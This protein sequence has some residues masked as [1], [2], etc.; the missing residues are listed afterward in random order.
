V[1][2][3]SVQPLSRWRR[4]RLAAILP[5]SELSATAYPS[6]PRK[7]PPRP[8]RERERERER[9]SR[10]RGGP[11]RVALSFAKTSTCGAEQ[12]AAKRWKRPPPRHAVYQSLWRGEPPMRRS[13]R[14][15]R[16]GPDCEEDWRGRTGPRSRGES[17][18]GGVP[19]LRV[20]GRSLWGVGHSGLVPPC[21]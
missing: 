11:P 2:C 14:P 18:G 5:S 8:E 12:L 15:P 1:P 9:E 10:S 13:C 7:G 4:H 20:E 3:R 16:G 17:H 21:S 6:R 19:D